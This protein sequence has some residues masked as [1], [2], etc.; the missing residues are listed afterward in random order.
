M[1]HLPKFKQ[2]WQ[3]ALSHAKN[4]YNFAL[5][6]VAKNTTAN[7]KTDIQQTI[8]NQLIDIDD[9]DKFDSGL[10][11]PTL[12]KIDKK[13]DRITTDIAVIRYLLSSK[14][15]ITTHQI[16]TQLQQKIATDF[17]CHLLPINSILQDYK[18]A[19]FDMDSTLIEQEVIV[20]LA[21]AT[22][23]GEQVNEITEQAMRGEIDFNQSFTQRVRLL[24]GTSADILADINQNLTLSAGAKTT[25]ALL[26]G[27]GFYTVLI[28]GGFVYFA[29]FIADKLNIK[30]VH[31]NEL[32]IDNQQV[33]GDVN[34]PILDGAKK[35]E[36][37][38]KIAKQQGV[39]LDKVICIGDGAND[40]QMMAIAH[41][42]MA[43]HAKPIVQ[44]Q[45]D[46]AINCTGLEG[47]IYALGYGK[48]F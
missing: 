16:I 25:L 36:I 7:L 34:L 47:V 26:N 42:G 5:I 38:K 40:L 27:L 30:E 15:P 2:A 14:T 29:Q 44:Q 43:Y 8:S 3:S 17:D 21:K 48:L 41:L 31:A 13:S 19:C 23:I 24:E 28:S 32:L 4:Q 37:V 22:G 45:A 20:E 12:D 39:S 10:L 46:T 35:A 6:I 1:T 11:S 33:T 9:Y 18:M